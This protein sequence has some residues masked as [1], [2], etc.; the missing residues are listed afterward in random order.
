M[1]EMVSV[2]MRFCAESEMSMRLQSA[3]RAQQAVVEE[4]YEIDVVDM[5]GT[6][7]PLFCWV[8]RYTNVIQILSA[9]R[10]SWIRTEMVSCLP[11]AS[12]A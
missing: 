4:I 9:L 2:Y 7:L 10:S 1:P 12:K 11:S 6:F 8:V 3:E 5:F